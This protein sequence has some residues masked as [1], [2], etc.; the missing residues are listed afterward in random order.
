MRT[1]RTATSG[2]STGRSLSSPGTRT[3]RYANTF[4]ETRILE[5][6]GTSK[7]SFA[8]ELSRLNGSR[9]AWHTQGLDS[10]KKEG[11]IPLH[12]AQARLVSGGDASSLLPRQF[13]VDTPE[14]TLI[15]K[16]LER[17]DATV[18][19][20]L[21]SLSPSL[22]LSVSFVRQREGHSI[23]CWLCG[24]WVLAVDAKLWVLIAAV[25]EPDQ[26]RLGRRAAADPARLCWLL[27]WALCGGS[28]ALP[29]AGRWLGG[30]MAGGEESWGGCLL[31]CLPGCVRR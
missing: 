16:T 8:Q 1:G 10:G 12:K 31:L 9:C 6:R 4:G 24:R 29:S 11:T 5:I 30:G 22:R 17:D 25:G 18:R 14:V 26:L 19:P 28:V 2:S 7:A 23:G 27:A 21:L 3:K 15:V 20:R 13:E